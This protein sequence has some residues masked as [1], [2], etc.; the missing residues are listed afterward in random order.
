MIGETPRGLTRRVFALANAAALAGGMDESAYLPLAYSKHAAPRVPGI[1]NARFLTDAAG[2]PE[3]ERAAR[4]AW[5]RRIAYLKAAGRGAWTETALALSG[6]G[7]DGA[8]GAGLLVGWTKRGDRPEFDY[9]TGVSTGALLAPFAYLGPGYDERMRDLFTT[10]DEDA[11]L[12]KRWFGAALTED[13]V[14]DTAPLFG[15]I[16]AV[17]DTGMVADIAREHTNGRLLLIG[18]TNIVAAR[19]TIWNLGAIAASRRPEAAA[20]VHKVLLASAA[21][22][23]LF[24][25]VPMDLDLDGQ[26]FRELHVDG[27]ATVGQF[28]YSPTLHLRELPRPQGASNRIVAY[29]VRNGRLRP[30]PKAVRPSALDLAERAVSALTASQGLGDLYREFELAK[31]DRVDLRYTAIGDDFVREPVGLF[32]RDYMNALFDYGYRVGLKGGEWTSTAPGFER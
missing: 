7:Q 3:W 20:L 5:A 9:V 11:L 21:I 10:V 8:F 23:T 25:P 14:Y 17:V 29:V 26:P 31:R 15:K 13:A 27:G 30:A 32:D 22:P 19:P 6:G 4:D 1:P 2:R 12:R 24:P 18:T 16:Q 28:L